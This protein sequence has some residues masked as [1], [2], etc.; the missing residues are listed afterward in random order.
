MATRRCRRLW[1]QRPGQVRSGR[2]RRAHRAHA[3]ACA[4]PRPQVARSQHAGGQEPAECAHCQQELEQKHEQPDEGRG[5]VGREA[6]T[7]EAV[8][9]PT[10]HPNPSSRPSSL[11]PTLCRFQA[12]VWCCCCKGCCW[13]HDGGRASTGGAAAAQTPPLPPP[14]AATSQA[15]RPPVSAPSAAARPMGGRAEGRAPATHTHPHTST[16]R[17]GAH[18]MSDHDR[19]G[20]TL[21]RGGFTHQPLVALRTR[22]P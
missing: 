8:F 5:A 19:V 15:T 22:T 12:C 21:R 10:M 20:N 11:S 17:R 1:R 13:Q 14:N 9:C 6:A 7:Q 3:R 4:S 18:P 2:C 16:L